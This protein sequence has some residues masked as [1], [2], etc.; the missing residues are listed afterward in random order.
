MRNNVPVPPL[1][2]DTTRW[3]RL[4]IG[5][6]DYANIRVMIDSAQ[7]YHFNI[8]TLAKT[9]VLYSISDTL[10]KSR[11]NYMIDPPYLTLT[12]KIGDDSVFIKLKRFDE[13]RFRLVNR[14]FR[15]VNEYPYNR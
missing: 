4:I 7:S 12:G 13:N 10:N 6:K 14:G 9:A 2:T 8:D 11:F 1:Q 3:N 15:W 5:Y